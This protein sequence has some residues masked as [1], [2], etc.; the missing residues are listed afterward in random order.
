MKKYILIIFLIFFNTQAFAEIKEKIIKILSEVNN[1]TF[2]FEQ[3]VNGV[4]EN[5]T[6]TI[7][8]PKKF[9][10]NTN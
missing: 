7:E 5:G 4:T 6:C 8:Y 1:V 10:A 3:N 2:N 9:F